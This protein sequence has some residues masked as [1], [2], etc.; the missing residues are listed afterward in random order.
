M[1]IPVLESERLIIRS[2]ELDDQLRTHMILN[3]ERG[4]DSRPSDELRQWLEWTVRN[5]QA[6]DRLHQPPYGERGVVRKTDGLLIGLVGLVP[7]LMPFGQLPAFAARYGR[8]VRLN[9]PEVGLYW[10]IDA[11]CRSQ[12]YASEAARALI[13]YGFQ[14]LRL[15]RIV[16]T[17]EYQNAA[18]IGVMR[19]LGM[20]I[21]R[22]PYPDP[23]WMQVVGFL[24][25]PAAMPP[26][27]QSHNNPNLNEEYQP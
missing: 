25:N 10:A 22:N 1:T 3:G 4:M 12:G 7:C 13:E 16:A 9:T 19:K 17:T 18:S 21:E 23:F 27:Q 8:E 14:H 24:D 2:L 6:L 26:L 11:V 20:S 5:E 15:S